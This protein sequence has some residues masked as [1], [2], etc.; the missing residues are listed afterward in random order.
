MKRSENL[1]NG[2]SNRAVQIAKPMWSEKMYSTVGGQDHL[3]IG[4][5]VTDKILPLLSPGINVLTP[6]PRYWSFYAFVVDEFWKRDLPR[7]GT[8]FRRFLRHKESI[9]SVAG[10]LCSNPMHRGMP[11]GSRRVG[12]LVAEGKVSYSANFDYMKSSGGGYGL[13]YATA[14][15]ATGVVRLAD[16]DLGLPVDA[17]T[18]GL[19]VEA[20][21][22]F[23][24][25]IS[26]TKYWK[27]YFDRD[28]VPAGVVEELSEVS[29]L[30]QLRNDAPDRDVLVKIFLNGGHESEVKSRQNTLRLI[31]ELAK[32]TSDVSIN[33]SDFRRLMLYGYAYHVDTDAEK[34]TFIPPEDLNGTARKWRISQLREYFN[35][36]L[37]GM[38]RWVT[39][40]G[41]GGEGDSVPISLADLREA[42]NRVSFK[43][44]PGVRT[45]SSQTIGSLIDECE[46]LA[47]MTGSLD[48]SWE[49]WADITEDHLINLVQSNELSSA[50][51]L[52]ALFALYVMS[53]TRLRNHELPKN[54][55]QEDWRLIMEGGQSRIG[56]QSALDQLRRDE[57]AGKSVLE[58]LHRVVDNHVISQHERV[59]L[60][61][62]PADTFRYRRNGNRLEFFAQSNQFRMNASRFESLSTICAEIGWCGVISEPN[63]DLTSEGESVRKFGKVVQGM[64]SGE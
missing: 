21:E 26:E 40:W 7:T 5:V 42:L 30:C 46:Q 1:S 44:V 39:E 62:L 23:R 29:C 18:P 57:T 61:K 3:G 51:E 33:E 13:Y 25:A 43:S 64:N 20:A 37:N 54:V 28:D 14:M 17:V 22:S 4:S 19:G 24:S 38:W 6:H 9:F 15:Q 27:K 8:S 48:G 41:L 56:M 52:G 53:L 10:H 31:L 11:I 2:S 60:S 59:A 35:W 16:R 47:E 45:K 34:A 55:G 58:V 49:L 50:E 36:S 63:H 12:P 32:Q